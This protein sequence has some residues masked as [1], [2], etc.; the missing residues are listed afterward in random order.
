MRSHRYLITAATAL[1]AAMTLAACSKPTVVASDVRPVYVST[2][3]ND[4]A[5]GERLFTGTLSPRVESDLAFR[6]GG[7]VAARLVDVGQTVRSGQPLARLDPG[8]YQL[9]VDAAAEHLRAAESDATQAANDAARSRRLVANGFVGAAELE[10]QQSKADAATARVEQS[11]RQ[12]DLARN[13]VSYAT[14]AAPFDGVV[15]AVRFEAGQV[16]GEGQSILSLARPG[17]LEVVVDV[18]ETMAAR[19]REYQATARLADQRG[20][21]MDLR[22][23]E[24]APSASVQTRTFRARYSIVA[25]PRQSELRIGMTAELRLARGGGQPSAQIPLSAIL[26]T[27]KTP[28]VWMVDASSG[29]LTQ[30]PVEMVSQASDSVRVRGLPDGALIV[31]VGAQKLDA[32]LK[33]RPVPRPL[34]RLAE[35]RP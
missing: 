33:V 10:R 4:S 35:V 30:Q 19:L 25:P 21:S 8:D 13:R 11:R 22:L 9:G 14:L 32:G 34:E 2:V 16:V 7:K 15:T 3:R 6:A 1:A 23:R 27:A 29:A 5:A 20:N 12:L 31:S 26:S 18:P 24:L 28:A 17:E